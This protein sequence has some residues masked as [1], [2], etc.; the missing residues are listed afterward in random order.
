MYM[1]DTILRS[2][3]GQRGTLVAAL[4]SGNTDLPGNA[5]YAIAEVVDDPDLVRVSEEWVSREAH[6]ASLTLPAV[7]D[8]IARARP[9]I[10]GIE[11][12]TERDAP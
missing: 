12:R 3:P 4:E 6:A 2:Q 7:Q 9:V 8:A 5:S 11:S 10:A 1:L